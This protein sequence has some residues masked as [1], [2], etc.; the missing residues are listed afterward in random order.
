ML[1]PKN[2]CRLAALLLAT[3]AMASHAAPIYGTGATIN[4]AA[5]AT[6]TVIDFESVGVVNTPSLTVDSV[7]FTSNSLIEIDSDYAG[8]YNTRGRYHITNHG[9]DPSAFRFDFD[10]PVDAFG[11]MFGASDVNWMLNAFGDNGLI[12]QL[13][14]QP[15]GGSNS[16]NYFGI[17]ASGITYATF[18]STRGNDYIFIDNFTY[19]RSSAAVPEPATLPLLGLGLLGFAYARRKIS[20]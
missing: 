5:L 14:V 12:E 3:G 7:T 11:F 15:T 17:A 18:A 16:G 8:Y 4:D 2:S 20:A 9:N 1:D 19:S 13:T 6:G 10:A